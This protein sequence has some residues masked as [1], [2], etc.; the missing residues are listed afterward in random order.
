[1]LST[2]S[3]KKYVCDTCILL[4]TNIDSGVR[5]PGFKSQLNYA[6]IGQVTELLSTSVPSS[7]TRNLSITER[8]YTSNFS[9]SEIP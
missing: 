4:V 2:M 8:A 9:N 7:V 3:G 6:L 1:M 5:H